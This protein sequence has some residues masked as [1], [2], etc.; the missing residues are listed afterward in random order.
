M[1]SAVSAMVGARFK[2]GPSLGV[3]P[4]SARRT[5]KSAKYVE[6]REENQMFHSGAFAGIAAALDSPCS[7][8]QPD[9]EMHA[10]G[11]C[12]GLFSR[13]SCCF[14]SFAFQELE[15]PCFPSSFMRRLTSTFSPPKLMSNARRYFEAFR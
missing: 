6:S 7:V 13:H 11:R 1:I 8:C 3:V 10:A 5:A 12:P 15:Y 2:A 14:V 9:P 4:S